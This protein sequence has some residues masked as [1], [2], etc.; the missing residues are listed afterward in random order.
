MKR[1]PTVFVLSGP[2][3]VG[4]TTVWEAYRKR[5][6]MSMIEKIVTTTSRDRRPGETEGEHYY[7]WTAERFQEAIRENLLIEYAV[8]HGKYYGST[9]AELERIVADRK[10]PLYIV[11][12]QGMIHIKPLL[13]AR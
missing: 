4:K 9:Y 11:D 5:Y 7:F 6:A 13:E 8:V 2:S 1:L 3:A 10:S 12:P